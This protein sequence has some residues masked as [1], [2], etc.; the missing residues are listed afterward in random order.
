MINTEIMKW[1]GFFEMKSYAKNAKTV[2]NENRALVLRHIRQKMVSRADICKKTGMPKSSVTRITNELIEEGQ[3]LEIGVTDSSYGRK[4]ILLDIVADYRYAAGI[5]LHRS[6]FYVCIVNLKS[7]ILAYESYKIENGDDPYELL[8]RAYEQILRFLE[9]LNIPPQKCIGIGVSAPGPVEYVKGT[10]LNPPDFK[11]FHHV[12]VGEYLRAKSGLPV[13]LDNNSV[14]NAMQEYATQPTSVFQNSM[15]VNIFGGIG[16]AVLTGGKVFRGIGGF[17]GEFGH[18]GIQP[19]GLPC[20]CGNVGCL[21]CYVSLKALKKAYQFESYEEM[22]DLAYEGDEKANEMLRFM[23][24]KFSYAMVNAINLFDLD[25]II[26]YGEYSYRP[27]RLAELL[28]SHVE[29]RAMVAR[30]HDVKVIFSEM[31]PVLARASV[32]TAI[33]NAYFEQKFN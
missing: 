24:E 28:Q 32:C 7:E 14:L 8:D 22:V 31:S 4:P 21:E 16:S 25:A 26:F 13:M 10:I 19:D 2:K 33:I 20:P 6:S 30:A 12:E 3:L 9:E 29:S 17:S 1:K 23:A 11:L 18:T 5:A 15:F 27:Q